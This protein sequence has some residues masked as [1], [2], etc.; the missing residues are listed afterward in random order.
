MYI[1]VI[2]IWIIYILIHN[3]YILICYYEI[4]TSA[5]SVACS[6]C[7]LSLTAVLFCDRPFYSLVFCLFFSWMQCSSD[8]AFFSLVCSLTMGTN[9]TQGTCDIPTH[10]QPQL[11]VS[12]GKLSTLW[13]SQIQNSDLHA[14]AINPSHPTYIMISSPNR[15]GGSLSE[16]H[17][18][19]AI[20]PFWGGPQNSTCWVLR[21]QFFSWGSRSWSSS[22]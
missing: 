22:F 21:S 17:P 8:Y 16:I 20:H 19:G 9:S 1:W 7:Y 14:S 15:N 3:I 11:N 12:G 18:E 6:N 13:F 10:C 4:C 5:L 2:H